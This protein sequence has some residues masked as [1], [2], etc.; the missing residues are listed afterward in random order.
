[1]VS[2]KKLKNKQT[3]KKLVGMCVAYGIASSENVFKHLEGKSKDNL[4]KLFTDNLFYF[5]FQMLQIIIINIL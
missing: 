3:N 1:M 4:V 2:E 5:I